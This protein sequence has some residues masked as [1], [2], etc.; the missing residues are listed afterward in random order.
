MGDAPLNQIR[1]KI[2]IGSE[3]MGGFLRD[4]VR[5]KGLAKIVKMQL[6]FIKAFDENQSPMSL[7]DKS[8]SANVSGTHG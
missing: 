8:T 2:V 5:C 6:H 1:S 7:A 3:Q 4:R